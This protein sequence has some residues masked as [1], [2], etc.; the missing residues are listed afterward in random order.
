MK[1]FELSTREGAYPVH[2][3]SLLVGEDL[4]TCLWGGTK[5]HIG[6]VAI[7]LPRPSLA[8][9]EVTSSTASV[10]TMVGHKED[11]LVKQISERLSSR[12]KRN[13]VV[14]AGIHWDS[15]GEDAIA[16]IA[17]NCKDL[18]E[19]IGDVVEREG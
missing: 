2:S 15:L 10:F 9:P 18:A 14:T 1:R 11:E 8:D 17:R 16:E 5:P 19:K 3:L 6:A 12:L 13:V 7:A 4:L